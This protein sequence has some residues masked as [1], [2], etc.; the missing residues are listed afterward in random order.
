MDSALGAALC[1][2]AGLSVVPQQYSKP[3]LPGQLSVFRS[4]LW[5]MHGSTSEKKQPPRNMEGKCPKHHPSVTP[6]SPQQ[7]H[8]PV[9][10]SACKR[11]LCASRVELSPSSQHAGKMNGCSGAEIAPGR[12]AACREGARC[13]RI[14]FRLRHSLYGRIA[15]AGCELKQSSS[16]PGGAQEELPGEGTRGKQQPRCGAPAPPHRDGSPESVGR[17]ESSGGGSRG[18]DWLANVLLCAS[19]FAVSPAK[20]NE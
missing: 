5:E 1:L 16:V 6:A 11:R 17:G 19:A 3:A 15:G 2:Q 13:S 10:P 12:S 7:C 8:F 9:I 20:T 4:K 14:H 18:G